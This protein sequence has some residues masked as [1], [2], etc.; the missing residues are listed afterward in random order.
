MSLYDSYRRDLER[1]LDETDRVRKLLPTCQVY[2]LLDNFSGH[3]S[4]EGAERKDLHKLSRELKQTFLLERGCN[5][6]YRAFNNKEVFSPDSDLPNLTQNN[7]VPIFVRTNMRCKRCDEQAKK[8]QGRDVVKY[9]LMTNPRATIWRT[10]R[11]LLLNFWVGRG[12]NPDYT[13]A[14]TSG[15]CAASG[16]CLCKSK[17]CQAGFTC[18][19]TGACG[20]PAPTDPNSSQTVACTASCISTNTCKTDSSACTVNANCGACGVD[21]TC[22]GTCGYTCNSGFIWNG[23]Q[24]VPGGAGKI[25]VLA[26]TQRHNRHS[27]TLKY[28][29]SSALFVRLKQRMKKPLYLLHR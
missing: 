17:K 3:V 15:T 16:E 10:W 29:P 28:S 13:Q 27:G 21:A 8:Q 22:A 20:C 19:T 6:F 2:F 24:C 26:Q 12:Y 23:S 11:F 18:S 5:G 7:G 14:C 25:R 9:I 4:V 1:L